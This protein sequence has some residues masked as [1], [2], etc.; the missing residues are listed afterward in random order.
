MSEAFEKCQEFEEKR[1]VFFKDTFFSLHNSLNI[2]ADAALATIYVDFK[3]VI[4]NADARKDLKWWSQNH[5]VDMPANW[6][7]FEEYTPDLHNISKKER[8]IVSQ[9][10]NH[11]SVTLTNHVRH[12]L[13]CIPPP[14]TPACHLAAT[15]HGSGFHNPPPHV[16]IHSINNH[17]HHLTYNNYSNNKSNG[18]TATT[19][20]SSSTSSSSGG[21]AN[22]SLD[23]SSLSK[24]HS[25]TT[26]SNNHHNNHH[27]GATK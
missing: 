22:N 13:S 2:A 24:K 12:D 21:S 1:L 26:A 4:D 7:T 25:S 5:G 20:S 10:I 14:P 8:K 23:P 27:H 3:Q 16:Q 18:K 9:M 17:S 11:D 15:H 6:P 19:T